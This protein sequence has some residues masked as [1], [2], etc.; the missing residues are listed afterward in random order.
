MSVESFIGSQV[1]QELESLILLCFFVLQQRIGKS[2]D[3]EPISGPEREQYFRSS[4][5][6]GQLHSD[7]INQRDGS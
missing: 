7:P 1:S 3:G 6:L 4:K 2:A 5:L